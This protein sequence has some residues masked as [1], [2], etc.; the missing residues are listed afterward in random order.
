MEIPV[1]IYSN[2]D[3]VGDVV[4]RF[5]TPLQ[6]LIVKAIQVSFVIFMKFGVSWRIW[7]HGTWKCRKCHLG[8]RKMTLSQSK[9]CMV[10]GITKDFLRSNLVPFCLSF[11]HQSAKQN[12]KAPKNQHIKHTICSS[13]VIF[14]LWGDCSISN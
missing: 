12:Q 11:Q 5:K 6:I 4:N 3:G 1:L 14:F 2:T 8:F 10:V 7:E 9:K 13:R